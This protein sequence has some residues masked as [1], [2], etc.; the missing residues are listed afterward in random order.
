MLREAVHRLQKSFFMLAL[1]F[2][3]APSSAAIEKCGCRI[4]CANGR[5]QLVVAA[6][7]QDKP[8]LLRSLAEMPHFVRATD[9]PVSIPFHTPFLIPMLS[10]FA[11]LIDDLHLDQP[12]LPI[13]SNVTAKVFDL[14]QWKQELIGHLVKP[15]QWHN[16]IQ[17]AI[18]GG[19]GTVLNAGPGSLSS[20]LREFPHIKQLHPNDFIE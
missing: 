4:A 6:E 1:S 20:I 5:L 15:V 12:T 16:S 10:E 8:A 7:Q 18:R 11:T 9:L 19:M 2:S 13:I 3:A 14:A 17:T